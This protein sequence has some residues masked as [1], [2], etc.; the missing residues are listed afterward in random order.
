MPTNFIIY[1][2]CAAELRQPWLYILAMVISGLL[3][4]VTYRLIQYPQTT[5]RLILL[6]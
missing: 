6:V 5:K 4:I 3:T 2:L 1:R